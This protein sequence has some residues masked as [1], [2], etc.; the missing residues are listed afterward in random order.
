MA[1]NDFSAEVAENYEQKCLCALVLDIS[2]SMNEIVDESNKIG[3]AH[4]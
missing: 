2:G 4:V 3:R 1:K